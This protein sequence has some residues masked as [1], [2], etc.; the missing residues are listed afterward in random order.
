MAD[1]TA[2]QILQDGPRN[3]IIKLTCISDGTGETAVTKVTPANLS[4][5][6]ANLQAPSSVEIRKIKYDIAGMTVRLLWD[7]TA[8]VVITT[9]SPG[10]GEQD[11]SKLGFLYNNAGA[12]KT[13]LIQLTSTAAGV[14]TAPLAGSTY[15]IILELIKKY[16]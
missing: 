12:G 16:T 7:A 11:Y 10:V 4:A 9:L 14:A 8:D 5:N 2:I 3:A 13:N 6:G 15:T 1:A